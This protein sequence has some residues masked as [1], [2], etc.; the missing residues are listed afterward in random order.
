LHSHRG[1]KWRK[2][3][4]GGGTVSGRMKEEDLRVDEYGLNILYAGIYK[5]NKTH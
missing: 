1:K 3:G 5:I 4:V 2:F